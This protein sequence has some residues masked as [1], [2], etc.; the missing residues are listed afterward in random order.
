[1]EDADCMTNLIMDGV[2]VR[3]A[4]VLFINGT[5]YTHDQIFEND[6][7]RDKII[8]DVANSVNNEQ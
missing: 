5:Y 6:E 7:I 1:M 8:Y 4:P 3:E 2:Y